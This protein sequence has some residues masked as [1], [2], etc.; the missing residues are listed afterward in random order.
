M[1]IFKKFSNLLENIT[2]HF[3]LAGNT[4]MTHTDAPTAWQ[5]GFQDPASPTM[6]GIINFHHD[7]MFFIVAIMVFVM[8]LLFRLFIY[9]LAKIK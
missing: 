9:T 6:E 4:Q 5:V 7:L 8:W 3:Q 2:V 1:F